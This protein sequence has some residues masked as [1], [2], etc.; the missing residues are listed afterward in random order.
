MV[1]CCLNKD[2]HKPWG[3]EVDNSNIRGAAEVEV[4]SKQVGQSH[5]PQLYQ[6]RTHLKQRLVPNRSHD[7]NVRS[8]NRRGLDID[9]S[10]PKVMK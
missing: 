1:F 4:R 5:Y 3:V 9:N 2:T 6:A 7:Y 10:Q 8:D